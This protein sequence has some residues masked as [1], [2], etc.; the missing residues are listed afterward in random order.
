MNKIIF[1]TEPNIL[2]I[3]KSKNILNKYINELYIEKEKLYLLF[4]KV[5]NDSISFNILKSVFKNYN[6]IGKINF[7]NNYNTLIN[8]NMKNIFFEDKIKNQYK[9]IAKRISQNNKIDQYYLEK[10]IN[11]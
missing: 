9:N 5:K 6:T 7:I 10:I 4:N 2:Q 3:K 1:I 8:Q 11:N